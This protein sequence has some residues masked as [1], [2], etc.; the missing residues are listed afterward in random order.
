MT[1]NG[2]INVLMDR[3]IIQWIDDKGQTKYNVTNEQVVY[4]NE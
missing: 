1:S 3:Y 4:P 2:W